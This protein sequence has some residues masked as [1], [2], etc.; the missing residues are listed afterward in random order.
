MQWTRTLGVFASGCVVYAAMAACS[1]SGGMKKTSSGT[2]TGQ[3]GMTAGSGGAGGHAG[4]PDDSGIFDVLTDP[5]PEADASPQSGTRLKAKYYLGDDG[6]KE[7]QY[8]PE[9]VP[10]G[11]TTAAVH[12]VWYDSQRQEDCTLTNASDGKIRCLPTDAVAWN[13]DYADAQC[14]IGFTIVPTPPIQCNFT[15]PKYAILYTYDMC[16]GNIPPTKAVYQLGQQVSLGQ[17][18]PV[19]RMQNGACTYVATTNQTGPFFKVGAL[20]PATSFAAATPMI[21][22]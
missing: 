2:T 1:S 14:T 18:P 11:N 9:A 6:A 15:P 21:D 5:V 20:V 17:Y 16:G 8:A 3:G 7:Y 19:Y 12:Q 22:P 13:G 10:N 4:S